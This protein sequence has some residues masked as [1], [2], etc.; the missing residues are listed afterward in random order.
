MRTMKSSAGAA[1]VGNSFQEIDTPTQTSEGF[2]MIS[3]AEFSR[4]QTEFRDNRTRLALAEARRV[5]AR[6]SA[7]VV[8][9]A[10]GHFSDDDQ[11]KMLDGCAPRPQEAKVSS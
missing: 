8:E 11:M 6:Q 3:A 7:Q 4:L 5:Q 10:A 9:P 2:A 1:L